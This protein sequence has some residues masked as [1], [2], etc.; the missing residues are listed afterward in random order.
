LY[1]ITGERK[2]LLY[3]IRGRERERYREG[4]SERGGD[5][6]QDNKCDFQKLNSLSL[7]SVS[8]FFCL[9]ICAGRI[10]SGACDFQVTSSALLDS[11]W[12]HWLLPALE[13]TIA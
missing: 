4:E 5:L 2:E 1:N 8:E 6:A 12:T 9:I 10:K 3:N 11:W 7:F 13:C